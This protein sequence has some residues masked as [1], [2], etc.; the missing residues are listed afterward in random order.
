MNDRLF[1][2]GRLWWAWLY[3]PSGARKQVSTKCTDR[4]AARLVLRRLEQEAQGAPNKSFVSLGDVLDGLET[5]TEDN[6]GPENQQFVKSKCKPLRRLMGETSD[7]R[8]ISRQSI[9]A[10]VKARLRE[11]KGPKGKATVSRYTVKREV[12]VLYQALLRSNKEGL[13]DIKIDALRVDLDAPYVPRKRWLTREEFEDLGCELD[14]DRWLWVLVSVYT[15]ARKSE[16][17]RLEWGDVGDDVIHI[18]GTK[19]AKSDRFV[20]LHPAL[21][22]ALGKRKTGALVKPWGG[23]VTE[24]KRACK[25]AEIPNVSPNDLRRTYASWLLQAGVTNSVVAELLGH[26]TTALVDMTYGKLSKET[27]ARAVR[28]I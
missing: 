21:G 17:E 15:G 27:L 13:T 14:Q 6:S 26:T 7:V 9:A 24:L 1:L 5:F 8:T 2:R 4:E 11:K 19:T 18:R 23:V 20:P 10:Y 3:D 16:V 28:L 25:R 12:K 22:E